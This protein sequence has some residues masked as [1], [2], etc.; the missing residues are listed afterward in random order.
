MAEKLISNGRKVSNRDG[1]RDSNRIQSRIPGARSRW[2]YFT[3]RFVRSHDLQHTSIQRKGR[4]LILQRIIRRRSGDE[5]GGT[6]CLNRQWFF[7]MPYM[8]AHGRLT[9]AAT[10]P[11]VCLAPIQRV[12]D[13]FEAH[14]V[15]VRLQKRDIL[16]IVG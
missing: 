16:V 13:F 8:V 9:A 3:Q 14:E 6:F 4:D 5:I 15:S 12:F 2:H 11:R 1:R 7:S 10:T